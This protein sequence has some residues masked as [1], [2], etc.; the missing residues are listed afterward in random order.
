MFATNGGFPGGFK[1]KY[2]W[3]RKK[4]SK[5]LN[6]I[7]LDISN[8]KHPKEYR[9]PSDSG[10]GFFIFNKMHYLFVLRP[11]VGREILLFRKSSEEG[12]ELKLI[13]SAG[14]SIGLVKPYYITIR[15]GSV[16]KNVPYEPGL[17]SNIILGN[18]YFSGFDKMRG[19][20]GINTRVSLEFGISAFDSF[21]TG[22][23][24]GFQLEA[25]SEKVIIIP[26]VKNR[27]TFTSAFVN[28]YFGKR[29]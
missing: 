28:F 4:N 13:L 14:P 11:N 16:T 10:G 12:L 1:L 26:D 15:D 8:I 22:L 27:A 24:L 18:S 17:N 21:V 25:F 2:A 7:S 3:L 19:V 9:L 6:N 29:Y 20:M 23:E 5:Q